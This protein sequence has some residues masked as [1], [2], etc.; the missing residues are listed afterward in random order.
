MFAGLSKKEIAP[1][2][3]QTGN[4]YKRGETKGETKRDKERQRVGEKSAD[5]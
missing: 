2:S 4:T 5:T 3:R 1:T